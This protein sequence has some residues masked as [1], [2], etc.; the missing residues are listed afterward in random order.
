MEALHIIETVI[1]RRIPTGY[2]CCNIYPKTPGTCILTHYTPPT[3]SFDSS[4]Y[5]RDREIHAIISI[6]PTLTCPTVRA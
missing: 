5:L 3:A 1:I 6:E 2:T 4:T